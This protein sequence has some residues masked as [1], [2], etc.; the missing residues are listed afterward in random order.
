MKPQNIHP[1]AIVEPGAKIGAGV[2]IEPFAVI[3][4]N[5]IIEDNVVVKSNAYIDGYTTI[6]EGSVIYPSACI[7]TKTQAMK[8][9]GEKTYVII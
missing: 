7:G 3:K 2:T 8:Y 5:V 9:K 6:G 1:L 4:S